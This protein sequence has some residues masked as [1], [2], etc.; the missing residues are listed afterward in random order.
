MYQR[1]IKIQYYVL[2]LQFEVNFH[3]LVPHFCQMFEILRKYSLETSEIKK[4]NE[5]IQPENSKI[6]K[7]QVQILKI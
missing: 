6:R 7:K 1:S 3:A 2:F 4:K 5:K